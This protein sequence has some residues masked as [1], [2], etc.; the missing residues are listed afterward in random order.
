LCSRSRV[1]DGEAFR[2]AHI[3]DLAGKAAYPFLQPVQYWLAFNQCDGRSVRRPKRGETLAAVR[4]DTRS[5][6]RYSALIPLPLLE[7]GT[8]ARFA[9]YRGLVCRVTELSLEALSKAIDD[10]ESVCV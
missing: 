3:D 6:A 1:L 10:G 4:D 9:H 7:K 5:Y 8:S 2:E